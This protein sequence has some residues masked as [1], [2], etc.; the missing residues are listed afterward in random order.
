MLASQRCGRWEKKKTDLA[1]WRS[2]EEK[3]KVM[4][5]QKK[6]G[7]ERVYVDNDLTW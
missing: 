2:R 6:L 4:K 3:E 5:N 7:V 1:K